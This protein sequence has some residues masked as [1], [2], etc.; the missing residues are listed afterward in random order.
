MI[1][2]GAMG[3]DIAGTGIYAMGDY[4]TQTMSVT[5]DVRDRLAKRAG[6]EKRTPLPLVFHN[7]I[8]G[9]NEI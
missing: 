6:F 2:R 5:H 3:R 9:R 1:R 4:D 8:E 7:K